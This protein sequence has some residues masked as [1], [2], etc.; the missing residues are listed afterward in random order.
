M[1]GRGA[2]RD[3]VCVERL[4][5]SAKYEQIYRHAYDSVDQVRASILD[6]FEWDNHERPHFSLKRKTPYQAYNDGMPIL[7]IAA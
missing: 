5:R 1:D 2:W 7:E 6:Y 4:G 3:N